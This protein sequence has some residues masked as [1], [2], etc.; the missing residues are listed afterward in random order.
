MKVRTSLILLLMAIFAGSAMADIL[1]VD[2]CAEGNNDGTSWYNA[3]NY[4]QDALYFADSNDVIYVAV[5]IYYPDEA[6]FAPDIFSGDRSESFVMKNGV[7]IVGGFVGN[8]VKDTCCLEADPD[9]KYVNNTTCCCLE[10]LLIVPDD[11]IPGRACGCVGCDK[12]YTIDCDCCTDRKCNPATILSGNINSPFSDDDNSYHVVTAINVDSSSVLENV[13]V[14]KGMADGSFPNNYGGGMYIKDATPMVDCVTFAFNM[15]AC[16]Q[17]TPPFIP[18]T[19]GA[20]GAVYAENSSATF[21]NSS[22]CLNQADDGAG[23][24][25]VFDSAVKLVNCVFQENFASR[26]GGAIYCDTNSDFD[27]INCTIVGNLAANGGAIFSTDSNPEIYNCIIWDNF[28]NVGPQIA[29]TAAGQLTKICNSVIDGG[30]ADIFI[31]GAAL[32]SCDIYTD[33]PSFV[34]PG[35]CDLR[36]RTDSLYIDMGDEAKYMGPDVDRDKKDRFIRTLDLGAYELP[37]IIYV[38]AAAV[39]VADG[40]SWTDAYVYLQDALLAAVPG[41]QIWV[42]QGVYTPDLYTAFPNLK[43]NRLTTFPLRNDVTVIGN[44]EGTETDITDRPCEEGMSGTFLSGDVLGDDNYADFGPYDLAG[45]TLDDNVYHIITVGAGVNP[46]AVLR[47]VTVIGGVADGV[48]GNNSF[49]GGMLNLGGSPTIKCVT[50]TYNHAYDSAGAVLNIGGAPLFVSCVFENNFARNWG[51]AMQNQDGATPTIVCS[52]FLSNL[53]KSRSGGAIANLA[54]T[55]ITIV[56]SEFIGNGEV[57]ENGGAMFSIESIINI[58]DS[59]FIENDA[60]KEGGAMFSTDCDLNLYGVFFSANTSEEDGG[61]MANFFCDDMIIANSV[62]IGN[63]SDSF[64]GAIYNLTCDNPL[65]VNCTFTQ[66]VSDKEGGAIYHGTLGAPLPITI[67][68]S[69]LWGN[70]SGT[71]EGDQLFVENALVTVQYTILQGGLDD[72]FWWGDINDFVLCEMV[73]DVDPLL[74]GWKLSPIS[75]AIDC[76]I[77][78]AVPACICKDIEGDPRFAWGLNGA[79]LDE[80]YPEENGNDNGIYYCPPVDLG[81]DEYFTPRVADDVC[82]E[83]DAAARAE[84]EAVGSPDCWCASVNPRQCKGDADGLAQGDNSYWVSTADL[85]ILL[86]AWNKPLEALDGNMICADFDHA[87]QGD[88]AYRVSTMD[89]AILLSNWQ[90]ADGPAADCQD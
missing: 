36:L 4:L 32:F 3:Y 5:G 45:T 78:E 23:I 65:F 27:I 21:Y 58:C 73:K 12:E 57:G 79:P 86:S 20:G 7:K 55:E 43:H 39:G 83:G 29:I 47:N 33:D 44:F 67:V 80:Q 42:A 75:P 71:G 68:N 25:G 11:E 9:K 60:D 64:G 14:A 59:D 41:D 8:T 76:G 61:A 82:F 18:I 22:F 89:L 2:K 38:D 46:S 56:D 50:F 6:M 34:D 52:S 66:N 62:F 70:F 15:A 84:W 24:A 54:G 53:A 87:A 35:N 37:S 17:N 85:A 74:N 28:A 19:G 49:A 81:A 30:K 63:I 40:T 31:E 77:N 26:S 88:N 16:D 1:Y 48:S 72:I 13:V 90:K 69:I 51:G 10:E